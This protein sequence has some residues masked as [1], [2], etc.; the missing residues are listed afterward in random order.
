MYGMCIYR[1]L[2]LCTFPIPR[3]AAAPTVYFSPVLNMHFLIYTIHIILCSITR[4]QECFL[5]LL[6]FFAT[7]ACLVE[8]VVCQEVMK[9]LEGRKDIREMLR[10][11]IYDV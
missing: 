2:Y 11:E 1:Y 3:A 6:F 8:R 7:L 5:L 10:A 4:Q 9:Q